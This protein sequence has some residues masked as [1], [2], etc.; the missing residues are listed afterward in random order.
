MP[1][2]AQRYLYTGRLI[3]NRDPHHIADASLPAAYYRGRNAR[4]QDN[5][6]AGLSD[7]L[8]AY[9]LDSAV[10]D[11]LRRVNLDGLHRA[12]APVD[13]HPSQGRGIRADTDDLGL[14]L[15]LRYYPRCSA[16][17]GRRDDTLRFQVHGCGDCS[18]A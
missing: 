9:K 6:V 10:A 8:R 18:K 11:I 17:H 12:H 3:Y 7:L 1:Q 5:D 16:G 4:S 13:L 2:M 14:R 15:E